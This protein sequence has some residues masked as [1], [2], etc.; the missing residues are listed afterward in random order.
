MV[1]NHGHDWPL[2]NSQIPLGEIVVFRT[3]GIVKTIAAKN[4]FPIVVVEVFQ[5]S[6]GFLGSVG[7]RGKRSCW[8]DDAQVIF[9]A[10]GVVSIYGIT[11]GQAP[12]ILTI[13]FITLLIFY[14]PSPIDQC[15]IP[16]QLPVIRI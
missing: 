1:F 7:E 8:G 4:L 11:S 16:V 6:H 2:V 13:T 3:Y 14:T 5:H 9:G 10:V 15:M 12:K